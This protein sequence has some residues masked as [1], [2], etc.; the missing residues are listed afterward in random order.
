MRDSY[1]S[2]AYTYTMIDLREQGENVEM[3]TFTRPWGLV[4]CSTLA[5]AWTRTGR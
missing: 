1:D 4:D 2:L 5:T 3:R